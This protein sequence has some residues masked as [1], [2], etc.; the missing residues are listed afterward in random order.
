VSLSSVKGGLNNFFSLLKIKDPVKREILE[1][2]TLID[3]MLRTLESSRRSLESLA[4]EY[5]KRAKVPGQD[6]EISKIIEEEV[7]NI[8]A[9][10]SLI[11]K[12]I[13]D[14]T[15][16][17]YRLETVVYIKEPLKVIPE[18]LAELKNIEPELEKINPQLLTHI[19]MLEQRVAS[20]LA[21]TSPLS[22]GNTGAVNTYSQQHAEVKERKLTNITVPGDQSVNVLTSTVKA[23]RDSS[24]EMQNIE[25]RVSRSPVIQSTVTSAEQPFKEPVVS[26]RQS[27]SASLPLHIVEQWILNELKIAAGILDLGVFEKKYGIPRERI[28]EALSSLEA[29]GLIKIRRK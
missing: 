9:Y 22:I 12:T 26:F 21:V 18:I 11:T 4:E 6:G 15:R 24:S 28:L 8:F 17:K 16:V 20:I 3:K 5:K 25:R 13:H 1:S 29:K 23:I 19:K 27:E 10:L 2:T 7:N 14:L